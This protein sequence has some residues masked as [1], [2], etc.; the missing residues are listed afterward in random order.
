M[1]NIFFDTLYVLFTTVLCFGFAACGG[2]DS[3]GGGAANN[4]TVRKL[5]AKR[6]LNSSGD[7]NEYSYGAAGELSTYCL[8]FLD[9]QNGV[10][11]W[12]SKEI[13]THYGASNNSGKMFFN[14]S[15][16]GNRIIINYLNNGGSQTLTF[17]ESYLDT[18]GDIYSGINL[19]SDDQSRMSTWRTELVEA[20]DASGYDA[21]VNNGVLATIKKIDNYHQQLDITSNLDRKYPGKKI[22]YFVTIDTHVP[23]AKYG[24]GYIEYYFEDNNNLHIDNLLDL[25]ADASI[26]LEIY[27]TIKKKQKSG[28]NLTS[29]EREMLYSCIQILNDFVKYSTFEFFVKINGQQF[30]IPTR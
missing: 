1:R 20:I 14:Y 26:Y 21:V 16:Q 19:T 5:M 3:E 28:Q 30:C 25:N 10:N 8:Y 9:A 18:G 22:E 24:N 17:N 7:Y 29:D 15:V 11:V 23:G 12:G 6:W 27:D 13:D 4:E 2:D